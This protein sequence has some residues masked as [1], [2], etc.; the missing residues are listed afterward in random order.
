MKKR[1]FALTLSA[2]MLGSAFSF[3]GCN[4]KDTTQTQAY[5]SM[6]INP[7]IELIVDKDN[8]VVSVRGENT[9]GL[10]LLYEESG[11]KGAKLNDAI[12]KITQLAVDY[13]YLNEENKTVDTLVTSNNDKFAKEVLKTVNASVTAT[14]NQS[15]LTVTAEAEGTYSL[16]RQMEEFKKEHPDNAAVQKMTVQKF[17]L[18]LSVSQNGEI[19]L[20]AAIEL[21]D[22]E[23]IE[24]LKQISP[25]VEEYATAAYTQAKTAAL[26][27]YDQAIQLAQYGV[28]AQ[29]YMEKILS[30]PLTAYYGGLYQ[31]YAT[32]AKMLNAVCD[33]AELAATV[34]TYPLTEEQ[35]NAVVKALKLQST[36]DIKNEQGEVTVD[37]I[38]AYADKL[39]KNSQASQEL[40]QMKLE[41]TQAL[42]Q[43]ESVIKQQLN[44]L[45][46]EYKP[47]IESAIASANSLLGTVETIISAMPESVQTMLNTSISEFKEILAE[48]DKITADGKVEI[49][50]LRAQAT[51]LEQKANE[52]LEK[53]QVDLTEEEA[54]ELEAKKA[55]V[56][57]KMTAQKQE[58]EKALDKA[59]KEARDYLA[60][61]KADRKNLSK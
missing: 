50:E 19:S 12:Q 23:L 3:I 22:G 24:M 37:S 41:L 32:S 55:A 28:Y 43:A 1:I 48:I 51:R 49:D 35:I 38:E 21:D 20:E 33:A 26:A 59:E 5:V 4:K 45:A 8:N 6:D 30:H 52:Y 27:A 56:T 42:S 7:S 57:Q 61:I 34:K 58:F 11:I 15:G 53:I 18:A 54:A 17:K 36:E 25:K 9:D 39:F 47:Q 40:E 29:F 44:R 13:G 2:M 10:V 31:T 60:Q 14:A 46:E 16:L